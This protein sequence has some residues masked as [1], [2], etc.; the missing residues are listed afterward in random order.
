MLKEITS[1]EA[2]KRIF[3]K[4]VYVMEMVEQPTK[5]SRA[6]YTFTPINEFGTPAKIAEALS[7]NNFKF[8]EDTEDESE[9]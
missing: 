3:E 6:K 2:E 7:N 4:T 8:V 5:N 1:K 9:F